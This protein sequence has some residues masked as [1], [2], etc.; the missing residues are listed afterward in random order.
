MTKMTTPATTAEARPSV[1]AAL[2]AALVISAVTL[3]I[4]TFEL[5][6]ADWPSGFV[7]LVLVP[8]TALTFIGCGLWSMTLLL[9]IR[10]HGL[11]F[12]GP[13]LVYA[14][15]LAALVYAPLQEIAL[16]RNFAWHRASRER[17]VA[18]VEA[19]ELKPNIATNENLIALGN[20]EANVSAGGNDIVVDQAENGSY[21]LFLTSRGLK[22]TFTGFLH[23]PAG[24]DPKDFFEFDDKPPSRLV[25]YDKDWY[26]VA[27]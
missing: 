7:L 25:R 18:R 21:V 19:G 1:R 12:A 14:L 4:A 2:I 13:F 11:K 27:N 5:A 26:F 10:S 17:I 6:M 8:L 23:V 22:H 20:G 24:A 15:T 16:Q 9:R 3:G